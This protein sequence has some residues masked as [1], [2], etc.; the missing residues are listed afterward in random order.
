[1]M[2]QAR[3]ITATFTA[4]HTLTVS[5]T[6]SGAGGVTSSPAGIDCG[7]DCSENFLHGTA[8]TLTPLADEHSDFSGW[9]GCTSVTGDTCTVELTSSTTVTAS[10]TQ[11]TYALQV[12]RSG[13][14]SGSVGSSD[15]GIMCGADCS[16]TFGSGTS[17]TLTA[18]PATGSVFWSWT[19]CDS[20]TGTQCTVTLTSERTV[21]A[22]FKKQY[23]LE[24]T[25]SGSGTV[26][27]SSS[28]ID[29]P[30]DCAEDVVDGT[31][32]TLTA[33]PASGSI[34]TGW[35]GGGCSG[36][37][38]CVITVGGDTTVAASFATAFTL[39]VNRMGPGIV[40]SSPGGISCGAD[41]VEVYQSGT[42][43]TLTAT[44]TGGTGTITWGGACL[45]TI[46]SQCTVTMSANRSVSVTFS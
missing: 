1:S 13:S 18:T 28:G 38:T 11:R 32:V 40:S 45:G 6:G 9:T 14:G 24:V 22:T 3:S 31:T 26:T 46:G 29:C 16:H 4:A 34:F 35:S 15:A 12:D 25:T 20:V 43:V 23:R 7:S 8:V 17:V 44:S 10:F 36:T 30:S 41:C 33:T 2:T 39:T 42:S 27:S 21:T 5:Q 37:G 19:G